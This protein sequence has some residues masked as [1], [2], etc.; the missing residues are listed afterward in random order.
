M[1]FSKFTNALVTI[2]TTSHNV[3]M[4]IYHMALG[5][6]C[7]QS[8]Y[9][10][11]REINDIAVNSH[12][13]NLNKALWLNSHVNKSPSLC[14]SSPVVLTPQKKIKKKKKEKSCPKHAEVSQQAGE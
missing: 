7:S 13:I 5:I 1:L 6:I 10:I 11:S 3:T 2:E 9:C 12:T 8:V 14:L 4:H